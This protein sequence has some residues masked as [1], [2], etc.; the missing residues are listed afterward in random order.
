MTAHQLG[1]LLMESNPRTKWLEYA[2]NAITVLLVDNID[3]QEMNGAIWTALNRVIIHAVDY[4]L[5]LWLAME[6]DDFD[7][8]KTRLSAGT[9]NKV[10]KH[11]E[12]LE[13]P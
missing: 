11:F 1:D 13:L 8:L 5:R 12:Q 9:M 4:D 2:M 6:G 3:P 10:R 7:L